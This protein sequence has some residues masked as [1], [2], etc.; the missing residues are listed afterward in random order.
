MLGIM[1]DASSTSGELANAASKHVHGV[2]N[3]GAG[4][5]QRY[6]S[7][8]S[9][10]R[11]GRA[12]GRAPAAGAGAAQARRERQIVKDAGST[13]GGLANAVPGRVRSLRNAAEAVRGLPALRLDGACSASPPPPHSAV[14]EGGVG[15]YPK[16]NKRN[17]G[18]GVRATHTTIPL[19][20]SPDRTCH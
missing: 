12:R 5:P 9:R 14:G 19:P 1:K 3:A 13:S 17:R 7:V 20:P 10:G 18:A 11:R 16:K 8:A 6:R 15:G 2:R 4:D